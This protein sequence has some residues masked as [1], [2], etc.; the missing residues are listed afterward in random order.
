VAEIGL[1]GARV[2]AVVG[3]LEPA[4][5]PQHVRMHEER[6][7]RRHAR[8]GNH[9]LIAVASRCPERFCLAASMSPPT[10]RSVR[11]SRPRLSTVTFTEVGAASRSRNVH[12]NSPPACSYCYRFTR[13]VTDPDGCSGPM[14]RR[15]CARS[16]FT[17]IPRL[18]RTSAGATSPVELASD[19][20]RSRL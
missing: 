15:S 4:G 6:E 5:M 20:N 17:L 3:E 14:E 12:G 2:V 11:Y 10:S 19:A 9:A 1:D 7:F 13:G 18:L 8:P 16:A